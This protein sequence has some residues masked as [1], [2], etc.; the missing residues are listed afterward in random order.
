MRVYQY[1]AEYQRATMDN[2]VTI[3]SGNHTKLVVNCGSC[4]ILAHHLSPQV[5]AES[6]A[7]CV[8]IAPIGES[9]KGSYETNVHAPAMLLDRAPEY[10]QW[11]TSPSTQYERIWP[12]QSIQNEK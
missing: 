9:H 11:P 6:I 1:G 10:S 4:N 5:A 7:A 8:R 3:Q 2:T 12:S